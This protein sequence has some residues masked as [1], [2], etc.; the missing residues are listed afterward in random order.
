MYPEPDWVH[1]YT[2]GSLLKDSENAGAEVYCHLFSFY[3]T[4]EKFKTAFDGEVAALQ[5]ALAQL[6]CHLNSFTR[7]IVFGDSKA[8]IFAVNSNSLPV[9]SNILDCKNCCRVCLS[10]LSKSPCS[11][12]L[13]TAV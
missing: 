9:S 12:Y 1:I 6:H 11:G 5:V 4:T 8:A 13:D 3:L 2:D 7:A 10:T